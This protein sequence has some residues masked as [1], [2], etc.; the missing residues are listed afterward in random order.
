[1]INSAYPW[2]VQQD[3]MS[4]SVV[5]NRVQTR[6]LEEKGSRVRPHVQTSRSWYAVTWCTLSLAELH[7]TSDK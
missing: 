7:Y 1:M 6:T 5:F 3:H 4:D 2:T